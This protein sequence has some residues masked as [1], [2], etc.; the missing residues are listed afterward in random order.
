VTSITDPAG[1]RTTIE[2]DLV[3]NKPT[4][5]IDALGNVTDMT[6]DTNRNLIQLRTPSSQLTTI[7]YNQYGQPISVTD[8]MGN[9]VTAE[10]DGYGNLLKTTDP[11]GNSATM[12]YDSL[13]RLIESTDARGR[14]TTYTYDLMNRLKEVKDSLNGITKFDYDLNGNLLSVTDAKGQ[15][16]S[17]TY[18][19]KDKVV[20]TR[21]Q[22]GRIETYQYDYNGNLLKMTDRKGQVTNST[23]DKFDRLTRIDYG[24]GSYTENTYDAVRRLIRIYDSVSGP[25]EYEYSNTGCT[26]GCSGGALDKVIKETSPLGVISYTYDAIGRRTSMTIAGQPAVNYQ[27]D[28]NSRLSGISTLNSQL[29]ALNFNIAYDALGRRTSLTYPNGVTTNYTYDNASNLLDLKHLNPLNQILESLNYTYDENGNRTNMSRLNAPVKLPD[30]K[31]NITFN[32]ANQMLTLSDK[33]MTYDENGNL[34]SVT[35]SCGTTT[36]T[37]DARKRLV[38]I[39]GYTSALTSSS[40]CDP[41]TASFKYDAFG[42]RIEK[43][44]NGRTIQYLY[45]GDDIVQE[46]ENGTVSAN[47]L[48]TL[49]IDEPLVYLGANGLRFYQTDAL[50]SVIALTDETG[51]PKTQYLY[52][53]FGNATITG[54]VSDN[55]FQYTGRENDGTGFYYYRARYYSPQ[56]QRFISEDPIGLLGGI[57]LYSYVANDPVN[58]VDA[59][60]EY[61]GLPI[62]IGIGIGVGAVAITGYALWKWYSSPGYQKALKLKDACEKDNLSDEEFLRAYEDYKDSLRLPLKQGELIIDLLNET[63]PWEAAGPSPKGASQKVPPRKGPSPKI[64]SSTRK[65]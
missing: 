23:Y 40:T 65:E 5:I 10:Y 24:D 22:L 49:I 12:K 13:S 35:N 55:P 58:K 9:T 62:I 57:N 50:G 25:I 53:P 31:S 33:S 51:G 59:R 39:D 36:Y 41:L 17:Y 4:K 15:A 43:T 3:W 20:T 63:K 28:S 64:P 46:I 16:I 29:G 34:T 6:Y 2:Y 54:E 38:A 45:D 60:G 32:S 48:R 52:D 7:D 18:N 37:W 19:S 61:I 44:V 11:L 8:P 27:F 26:T 47:Y 21:D 1:N 56:L 30:P 42:R 14:K